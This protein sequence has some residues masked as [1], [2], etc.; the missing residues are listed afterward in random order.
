MVSLAANNITINEEVICK[1]LVAL[2]GKNNV[3]ISAL[4]ETMKLPQS[5]IALKIAGHI[6][7]LFKEM[8]Y[9]SNLLGYPET[10]NVFPEL[11]NSIAIREP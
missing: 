2:M 11:Y 1:K 5:I 3:T 7:W 8:I 9:L 6:D 10:K 4:S